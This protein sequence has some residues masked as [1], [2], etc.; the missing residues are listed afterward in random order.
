MKKFV[1]LFIIILCPAIIANA[2]TYLEHLQ[3]KVQGQGTV[4]VKQSKEIDELVNGK[5]RTAAV[6]EPANT[7]T[8]KKEQKDTKTINKTTTAERTAETATVR[9]QQENDSAKRKDTTKHE[10]IDKKEKSESKTE[11][12]KF[13]IP[14]LDLRKKVPRNIYKVTGYRVQV[15]AGGNSRADRQ[16][17]ESIRNQI[18]MNFPEEPIYVQ[19]YSPRWICRIGN[20]RSLEE[21]NIVLRKIQSMGYKQACIVKGKITVQY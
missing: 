8:V 14:T 6:K 19:S 2:Q 20:Y 17:A 15:F 16:R 9:Q 18:K 3:K 4:I 13:D 12:D 7:Q 5:N 10:V 11:T 1:T 21:A